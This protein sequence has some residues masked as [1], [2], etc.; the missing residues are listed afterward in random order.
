MCNSWRR[1]GWLFSLELGRVSPRTCL[2][3]T[4]PR[5]PPAPAWEHQAEGRTSCLSFNPEAAMVLPFL[6]LS[7]RTVPTLDVLPSLQ[8]GTW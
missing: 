2:R 3:T 8:A 5:A 4:L 7:L 1:T 6:G